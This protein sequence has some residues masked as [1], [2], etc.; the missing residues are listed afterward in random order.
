MNADEQWLIGQA[1]LGDGLR[2]SWEHELHDEERRALLAALFNAAARGIRVYVSSGDVHVSA[3]FSI[4]DE[5]HRRIYQLT[6]SVITYGTARSLSWVLNVGTADE[7]ETA[8][9]QK[10]QRPSLYADSSCALISVDPGIGESWFKLYGEQKLKPPPS[11]GE[12]ET[13]PLNHSVAKIR[14]F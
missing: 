8:E 12:A 14:L 9:G 10:F 6:S 11:L 4:E 3:V 2:D 5:Q 7:R 13:V 1:G